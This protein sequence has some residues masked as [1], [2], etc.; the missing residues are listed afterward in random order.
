MKRT[1]RPVQIGERFGRLTAEAL[2]RVER[3]G[4][5][6]RFRCDCGQTTEAYGK[7]AR[8]G[9]TKSCGCLKLETSAANGRAA[10]RHGHARTG[11][12]SPQYRTWQS[13]IR[14]CVD[15]NHISFRYYG[16]RGISVCERWQ[17]FE[18]FLAD[19]PPRPSREHSIDRINV[20]GN[21]EPGNVRWATAVEQGRNKT[22]N[23]IVEYHG[24]KMCL[25]EAAEL[26]GL[27]EGIVRQ[28]L[29]RGWSVDRALSTKP[30][31]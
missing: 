1:R 31:R 9:H 14:R 30:M 22:K 23:R 7:T 3:N 8:H 21:Y 11:E 6:M 2:I 18:N 16:A 15:P 12:E 10:L 27:G 17:T 29:D 20:N 28:R 25:T 13:M 26:A 19:M 24:R 5:L 4:R